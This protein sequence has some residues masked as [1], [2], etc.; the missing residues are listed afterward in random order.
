MATS[1]PP[2]K[3]RNKY[4]QYIST[5]KYLGHVID[6]TLTNDLDIQRE[7]HNMLMRTNRPVRRF[8]ECLGCKNRVV[9]VI[10]YVLIICCF[11]DNLQ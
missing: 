9:Q 5:F 11:I 2:L 4:L 6:S 10:L 8:S 7:I 3:I 1:F